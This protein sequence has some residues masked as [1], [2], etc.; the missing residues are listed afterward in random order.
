[1]LA[2]ALTPLAFG[3]RLAVRCDSL[4][5]FA[6][7]TRQAIPTLLDYEAADPKRFSSRA[8]LSVFGGLTMFSA[9]LPEAV[10]YAKVGERS[11]STFVFHLGGECDFTTNGFL[12]SVR[13]GRSAAFIPAGYSWEVAARS[14]NTA[15]V[16]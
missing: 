6:E 10:T 1:M 3:D 14:S 16:T 4:V 12:H 13:P 15:V 7:N 11:E 9:S 5:T 8:S 2:S